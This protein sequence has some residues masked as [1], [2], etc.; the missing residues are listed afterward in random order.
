MRGFL[1]AD[2]SLREHGGPGAEGK[3]REEPCEA[4]AFVAKKVVGPTT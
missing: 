3:S 4:Y 1:G 2:S